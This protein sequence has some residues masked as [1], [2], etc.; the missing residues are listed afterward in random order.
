MT[1][2]KFVRVDNNILLE[3][4]YDDGNLISEE[5][6]II[7]NTNNLVYS[8]IST[9]S[10]TNN[11]FSVQNVVV[12]NINQLKVVTNQLA[13]L[14]FAQGEW[15]R[16][17]FDNFSFLQKKDY[18]ISIP[19]RYDKLRIWIPPNYVF[20]DY[21]GF[22]IKI[23]TLDFENRNFVELSN[24]FF[25]VTDTEQMQQMSYKNPYFILG[26]TQ[27][28][29][30]V[31]IQIPSVDKVSD[32]RINNITRE[33]TINWNLTNG[34]GLSKSAPVFVNFWFIENKVVSNGIPFYKLVNQKSVNFPQT[35]E[36]QKFGVV[37]EHSNQG[38]YFLIYPTYNGTTG[39]FNSFIEESIIYGNRYY[40]EYQID[41]FEKN[42]KY[43]S[44][45]I[46]ITEDFIEEI[47]Y[48]PILKFTTTTAIIDVTCKLIDAVDGSEIIRKA[49]YAML[50]DEVSHYS[51][52]LSKID[53]TKAE[54]INVY[55]IKGIMTPNLDSKSPYSLQSTLKIVPVS[56]VVYAF[57]YNLVAGNIN[58]SFRGEDFRAN[59]QEKIILSPFDN[60]IKFDIIKSDSQQGYIPY[61]LTVFSSLQ[62][63]FRSDKKTLS[64][65]I[66]LDSD[67]NN[68]ALGKIVFKIGMDKYNDIKK[69]YLSGFKMFY[70]TGIRDEIKEII[71][72]GNF[73]CWDVNT[74]I[75]QLESDFNLNK[76]SIEF[77][78]KSKESKDETKLIS[79]V[80][81]KMDKNETTPT[82]VNLTELRDV[83]AKKLN[84]TPAI[85]YATEVKQDPQKPDS[86]I[87]LSTEENL[88][89]FENKIFNDWI[90][91]WKGSYDVMLRA[92]NYKFETN[93]TNKI[94][95]YQKPVDL[96]KFA[97][98]LKDKGLLSQID[99]IKRV[100]ILSKSSR[101]EIEVILN[102]FKIMN[103]N[104]DDD[105]IL[106]YV[107][108]QQDVK[109]FIQSPNSKNE[110][111]ISGNVPPSIKVVDLIKQYLS[112]KNQFE[113]N[114]NFKL[115][116]INIKGQNNS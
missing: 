82:S 2:S 109:N 58:A 66:F 48:R 31:E 9:L 75:L 26:E 95:Q 116:N 61:D 106:N 34:V 12:N 27:W 16:V 97:I 86:T 89:N 18:G 32:Q 15:V 101:D 77:N 98:K 69:I 46:I 108:S 19:I 84:L 91:F 76:N 112:V 60:V 81:D 5:Y 39:E 14:D 107:A 36:F 1:T 49:T 44:Q 38:D 53:L 67:Q 20:Q 80:K 55:Q 51:K 111:P 92:F 102:Y 37:I 41:I 87:N 93:T 21:I 103:F 4:V 57:K 24:Y 64:F 71:Y 105:D 104:P 23:F 65:D 11:S 110:A 28:G 43:S 22:Y 99:V 68:L 25:D 94:N 59:N 100:G 72:N 45:K 70:I 90:P 63:T 83:D 52:Y 62:L 40:L 85:T 47:E 74:N 3:Y 56:F 42:I 35:P 113:V 33:N 79:E 96:R 114:P 8:F 17:D 6:S 7:Y 78:V 88:K 30:Y 29:K 73:L 50:Q 54:K 13:V 115:G 10:E